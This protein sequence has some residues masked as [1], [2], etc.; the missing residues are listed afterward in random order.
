MDDLNEG[1]SKCFSVPGSRVFFFIHKSS[2]PPSWCEAVF[3][4]VRHNV[5][6]LSASPLASVLLCG[7]CRGPLWFL[8]LS[9]P[10]FL[11]IKND[12]R[13]FTHFPPTLLQHPLAYHMC[14][15]YCRDHRPQSSRSVL[16]NGGRPEPRCHPHGLPAASADGV[17]GTEERG[18][19][20]W[21][22]G[23]LVDSGCPPQLPR[24]NQNGMGGLKAGTF[25]RVRTSDRSG[26]MWQSSGRGLEPGLTLEVLRRV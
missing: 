25:L 3:G 17:G 24:I 1:S 12:G 22:W 8:C 18:S 26:A 21:C 14:L 2:L 23:L 5:K 4:S 9:G 11:W 15:L 6:D 19:T 13:A 10:L 16:G 7:H 20:S